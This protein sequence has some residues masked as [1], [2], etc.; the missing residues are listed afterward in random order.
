MSMKLLQRRRI[1][2][3]HAMNAEQRQA[4]DDP[5]SHWPTCRQLR[6]VTTQIIAHY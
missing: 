1:H 3:I 5:W 2:P 6:K 4:A